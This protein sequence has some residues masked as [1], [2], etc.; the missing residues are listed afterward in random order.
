LGVAAAVFLAAGMVVGI[1][2]QRTSKRFQKNTL[3]VSMMLLVFA[4]FSNAM[5][6]L[7]VLPPLS[8]DLRASADAL[9]LAK[10]VQAS[11]DFLFAI[12]IGVF[13][14]A[15]TSPEIESAKD[16]RR[17]MVQEF[18]NLFAVYLFIMVV[19]IVAII[20]V[21]PTDVDF[22]LWPETSPVL[23]TFPDYFYA[24]VALGNVT[25]LLYTPYRLMTYLHKRHPSRTVT[26]NT[27]LIIAGVN[28][29]GISEMLFEIVLPSVFKIDLRA[30]GFI[31]E[32]LLLS[33]VAFAIREKL[34][35]NELIVPAAEADLKTDPTYN[36]DRGIGYIIVE[37]KP[38]HSFE[39]FR[40]L[41]TH[42]AQGLCI[43]R[44]PP[45]NVVAAYGLEKTPI[46]WLSRVANQKN[47]LR[48]SP[49]ENIAMA[50]EHFI[51]LGQDSVVLIDGLEYL[52][53]H[54]DFHSVLALLHDLNEN[55]SLSN[56][57]LLIPLDPNALG[58]KE[59]ALLRRDLRPI[60]PSGSD[61]PPAVPE[62]ML[63][64]AQRATEHR[65]A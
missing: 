1:V 41:V 16:F 26:R 20:T 10:K 22:P 51:S 44:Q 37:S 31:V 40:D 33:L 45:K 52:I 48:P 14:V 23:L 28:G 53:A 43:T 42:G 55:V 39:I 35:L 56:S 3:L 25:Q 58:E 30:G 21:T 64:K 59:F 46:L 62:V 19:A 60:Y 36:L 8:G 34:F 2:R 29:Y 38:D 7:V 5:I 50:V 57:I 54:N 27:Y 9:V 61:R 47:C 4:I 18:P 65:R 24:I 49:P 6:T 13:I 17:Q 15:T 11:L 32:V 12:V 63:Q